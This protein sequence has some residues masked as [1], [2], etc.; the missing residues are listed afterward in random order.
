MIFLLILLP[1]TTPPSSPDDLLFTLFGLPAS[2]SGLLHA[3]AITLKANA[4]VL[5]MLA[6][7]GTMNA[8]T[9][10][11][12]L[13]QLRLPNKLV[14]LLLFMVRYLDVIGSEY[15]RMRRAMTARGFVMGVNRHTW[16]SVGYLVGML[17]VH[18]LERAERVMAA[19]KCRGFTGQFYLHG[20][21]R[22]SAQDH[23]FALVAGLCLLLLVGLNFL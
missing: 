12:A 4:V 10:G 11:H 8:T 2:G 20:E 5:M 16:R 13:A 18:S 6:L 19:M 7:I 23:R 1:F 15:K 21:M 9:L 17:L 22:L 14:H 3:L